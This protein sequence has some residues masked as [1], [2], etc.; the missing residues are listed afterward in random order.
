[1][2]WAFVLIP[3][4]VEVG[5]VFW[6]AVNSFYLSL[7]EWNGAGAPE[8]VGLSNFRDLGSDEIFRTAL[9]NNVIW[10]VGFGFFSV[11]LGLALAVTLNRSAARRR[12]LSQRHL[13]PHGLLA[14]RDRLVLA[15]H[16][17]TERGD[18]LRPR[19]RGPQ[20]LGKQ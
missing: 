17:R 16:V 1:M 18:Q 10:A 9:K 19:S 3:L 15:G 2:V 11:A 14:R 20:Q 13:P 6:P 8:F 4:V 5:W 12:R 7:T